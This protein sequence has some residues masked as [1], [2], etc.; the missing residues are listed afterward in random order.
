V[1]R[2]LDS[3]PP[4]LVE[5]EPQLWLARSWTAMDLGRVDDVAEWLERAPN[6]DPWVGVLRALRLLKLGDAGGA[7]RAAA[8]QREDE[9]PDTFRSTVAAL[10]AGIAAHWRGRRADAQTDLARAADAA[11]ATGNALARQYALGYLALEAVDGDGPSAGRDLIAEPTADVAGEPRVEEHFTAMMRHFALGRVAELEGRLTEAERELARANE[12]S[13]RGA[14]V[15]ERAAAALGH[16]RV[17]AAL[18][19]RDAARQRLTQAQELL[20]RCADPGILRGALTQAEHAPGLAAP[21]APAA[22]GQELSERELGVLRLLHSELSL[23]EIGA[24][25]F[26]SLNTVKTHTR[27]IYLKLDA[28][29]RD[30]AVA[31]ARELGLL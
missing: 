5:S 7:A 26:V 2:W 23:R 4:D 31:R 19:S 30:E 24:E 17:L 15:L 20:A 6:D 16:A 9:A 10:V 25:L 28:G 8:A 14:G 11:L 1:H 12:L 18:G 3:L 21:R 27:N 13:R 29:G 22:A